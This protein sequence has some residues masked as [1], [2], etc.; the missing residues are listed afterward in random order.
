[1]DFHTFGPGLAIDK[2]TS[3]GIPTLTAQLADA[4]TGDPV[5]AYSMEDDPQPINVTTNRDGYFTQFQVPASVRR[6][7]MTFG[8]LTLEDTAWELV[9]EAADRAESAWLA[10]QETLAAAEEAAQQAR[11]AA[12]LVGA[13]ADEAVSTLLKDA[14]SKTRAGLD[15][16]YKG[17]VIRAAL[18]PTLESMTTYAWDG[19]PNASTS[20]ML[21]AGQVARQNLARMPRA[22]S[23]DFAT[24][25]AGSSSGEY[26]VKFLTG[27]D[28]G[29]TPGLTD[30]V[31]AT[32]LVA[33]PSGSGGWVQYSNPSSR[34]PLEGKA[35]DT[36]T[37]SMYFRFTGPRASIPRTFRVYLH[38]S[39]TQVAMFN[40]SSDRPNGEWVQVGGTLTAPADFT[41]V[42]FWDY[43]TGGDMSPVGSTCDATGLLL[44][45]SASLG[46]YFDGDTPGS[47]SDTIWVSTLTGVAHTWDG[48]HWRPINGP[49][50]L[51]GIKPPLVIAHRGAAL[52]NPEHSIE[53]YEDVTTSGFPPELDIQFLADGTPVICHDS[54]VN[55]T[56]EGVT[57]PV[58]SLTL[59][60]WRAARIKNPIRDGRTGT[61]TT[62]ADVL[63]RFGGRILLVPE[64]K[65]GAT[66]AQVQQC[67]D[68]VKARGLDRAVLMQSFDRAA[69]TQ[70]Q[71]AGLACIYLFNAMPTETPADMYAAGIRWVG[72]SKA[73][74]AAEL[75]SLAA[76]GLKVIPYGI[77]TRAHV[78]ALP[79][80][81]YGY[82]SDD[83]WD[84]SGRLQAEAV[85]RWTR[86]QAAPALRVYGGKNGATDDRRHKISI[87][88]GA[89]HYRF[90]DGDG[91]TS[92]DL[93]HMTGG[94][95]NRPLQVTARFLFLRRSGYQS[96]NLG[97]TVYR[98][99]DPDALFSDNVKPG[100][101]GFTFGLRR[102]GN[103]EGWHYTNGAK[104]E[105]LATPLTGPEVAPANQMA[106]ATLRLE[107]AANWLG[108][109][110]VETQR[111]ISVFNDM[112]GPFTVLLR[113]SDQEFT[114]HD[115][116][117]TQYDQ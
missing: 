73:R 90:D 2:T 33:A 74:S 34:I 68:M 27:Q 43:F 56:M 69:V 67:I 72:P 95:I 24:H 87:E 55:R 10:N 82:F 71:D 22:T 21:Q 109:Y 85:A 57:G 23:S 16:A 80:S 51:T 70:M 50:L 84:N 30:Y 35:G 49:D 104:A 28:D 36:I 54:T 44:E 108:F 117:I 86:G 3:R 48:A 96:S 111:Y 105:P 12:N 32:T 37:L 17:R 81:V 8:T 5:Q 115:I 89:L 64:V 116:S 78:R 99:T 53:A 31:R 9:T 100:Q 41:H 62:F 114:V 102:N 88:G 11:D 38:N 83:P 42:S 59:D 92:V 79:S 39:S 61:P 20:S 107:M 45:R 46:E 94:P 26:A 29:P 75:N 113:S 65:P 103:L 25:S 52:V 112:A 63:D 40:F 91:I 97:F 6:L 110:H 93:S 15:A 106:W 77:T 76:A 7:R 18:P 1:M 58:S 14:G 98:N 19:T 66:P 101:N 60:Q 13:P 4:E 47:L